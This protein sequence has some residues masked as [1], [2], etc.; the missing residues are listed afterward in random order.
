[1]S[2]LTAVFLG[3]IQGLTEFLPVSSSGHLSLIQNL[4]IGGDVEHEHMF[5]DVLLHLATLA[6]VFVVYRKDIIELIREFFLGIGAAV[7]RQGPVKN[8]PPMRRFVWMIIIACLPLALVPLYQDFVEGLYYNTLFIG[9]ALLATG[10]LLVV[11]DKVGKGRKNEANAKYSDALIVGLS[12]AVA[13]VPGLSR[14]GTTIAVGSFVGFERSFAVKFSFILS[15]PAVLG[16]NIL[17][18]V[19]ALSTGF[20]HSLM[21]VYAAGMVSAFVFGLLAM[22]LLKFIVKKGK[23]GAFSWYCFAAGA[24][25]IIY[26]IVK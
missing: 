1:M 3:F 16:A 10:A 14:S 25:A 8:A 5:F 9:F 17:S 12:Q 7:K 24:A 6:A 21:G 20:D 4:F 18:L 15:M 19:D 23:F 2:Y 11:C 22:W 26:T 13:V